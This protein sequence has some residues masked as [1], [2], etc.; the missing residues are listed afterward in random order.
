MVCFASDSP[1]LGE[2]IVNRELLLSLTLQTKTSGK[3]T[4]SASKNEHEFYNHNEMSCM[5]FFSLNRC[6]VK[7]VYA[8]LKVELVVVGQSAKYLTLY[9]KKQ[10]PLVYVRVP[11]QYS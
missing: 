8:V 7:M 5:Y 4:C 3:T 10:V 2:H 6:S 9:K 11:E 1:S